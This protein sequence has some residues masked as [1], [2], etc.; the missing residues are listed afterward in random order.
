MWDEQPP[1]AVIEMTRVVVEC[2][3]LGCS[4]DGHVDTY[5]HSPRSANPIHLR[6]YISNEL[7]YAWRAGEVALPES[8]GPHVD[9]E[10]Q[11]CGLKIRLNCGFTSTIRPHLS[12]AAAQCTRVLCGWRRRHTRRAAAMGPAHTVCRACCLEP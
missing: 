6:R 5:M 12:I 1:G 4:G 8:P 7:L 2:L 3:L 11:A 10:L 9:S